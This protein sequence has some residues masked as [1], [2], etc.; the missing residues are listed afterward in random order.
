MASQAQAGM[1]AQGSPA[2]G[3]RLSDRQLLIKR[4]V[5]EALPLFY[6]SFVDLLVQRGEWKIIE[7]Q[8]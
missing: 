2:S 7:V 4:D 5:Y 8:A 3:R 1:I 6:R